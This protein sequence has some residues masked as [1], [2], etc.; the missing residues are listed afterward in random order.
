MPRMYRTDA[1]SDADVR[2]YFVSSVHEADVVVFET[3]DQ[4][5]ADQDYVW[6]YTGVRSDADKVVYVAD[7]P[8][9]AELLVY[10]ADFRY[11]VEWRDPGKAHLL[12]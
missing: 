1:P 9:A 6:F 2:V 5:D 8:W 3:D 7:S 4:W 10:R 12:R 11:E